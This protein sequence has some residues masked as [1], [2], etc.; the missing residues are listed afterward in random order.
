M[1]LSETFQREKLSTQYFRKKWVRQ[2]LS[3]FQREKW[4]TQQI[5]S[6]ILSQRKYPPRIFTLR[7]VS[8][9]SR[10]RVGENPIPASN[11][12]LIKSRE[13]EEAIMFQETTQLLD[14]GL[15]GENPCQDPKKAN[16]IPQ[17]RRT[18]A[19]WIKQPKAAHQQKTWSLRPS[20]FFTGNSF[21]GPERHSI[22][23]NTP[24]PGDLPPFH[25]R[26]PFSSFSPHNHRPNSLLSKQ[27][28]PNAPLAP[29]SLFTP[30]LQCHLPP[31]PPT[32]PTHSPLKLPSPQ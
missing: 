21:R 17:I 7:P 1:H 24:T 11:F 26:L 20:Q 27:T 14:P 6:I 23:S 3:I 25:L 19:K 2:H 32:I 28:P 5:K 8:Q 9:C 15:W 4:D 10:S 30:L 18:K 13:Q 12:L 29:H 16:R 31:T 22:P